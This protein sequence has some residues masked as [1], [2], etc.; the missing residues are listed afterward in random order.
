MPGR[1]S[2]T[3]NNEICY[4]CL[5]FARPHPD[6]TALHCALCAG[7]SGDA[8]AIV[9]AERLCRRGSHTA[10]QLLHGSSSQPN[11]APFN[12][13]SGQL[14]AGSECAVPEWEGWRNRLKGWFG[15]DAG[16]PIDGWLTTCCS[17]VRHEMMLTQGGT[18]QHNIYGTF[19][20]FLCYCVAKD[21]FHTS[22]S[23][24]V[25]TERGVPHGGTPSPR[26]CYLPPHRLG[27]SC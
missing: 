19:G 7:G 6:V 20:A 24:F 17:Q 22:H 26:E 14:G 5:L 8:A 13:Q 23:G 27:R 9:S 25:I 3:C 21:M 10:L 18:H 15:G 1:A 4:A 12:A 16:L 2:E 11:G